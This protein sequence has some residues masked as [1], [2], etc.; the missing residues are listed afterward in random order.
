MNIYVAVDGTRQD[1]QPEE[2]VRAK[3]ASGEIPAHALC[4]QEGWAEWKTIGSVFGDEFGQPSG[5]AFAQGDAEAVRKANLTHEAS[6]KSIGLLY[7]IS[8]GFGFIAGLMSLVGAIGLMGQSSSEGAGVSLLVAIA[9][10]VLSPLQFIVA[11]WLRQLNPKARTP[12]TIFSVL[13]LLGFPIGTIINGY[14]LYLLQSKKG[15]TVFSAEYAKVIAATPHIKYKTPIV[16][17]ILF[18]LVVLLIVAAIA[19]VGFGAG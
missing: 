10:L 13:G 15:A 1:P 17:W 18:G 4:W 5:D 9:L 7:Y 19:A 6:V 16:V 2:Q 14:F 12:A 8:A 11:R 3:F